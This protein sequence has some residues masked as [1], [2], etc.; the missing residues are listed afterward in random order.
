MAVCISVKA[1]TVIKAFVVLFQLRNMNIILFV[2]CMFFF[3]KNHIS[4]HLIPATIIHAR[5]L[6]NKIK[7]MNQVKILKFPV[8]L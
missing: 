8:I 1:I 6:S 2:N 5:E 4:T 3:C 7:A